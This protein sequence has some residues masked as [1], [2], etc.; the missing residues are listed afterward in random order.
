MQNIHQR[1]TV[2]NA[3]A[4]TGIDNDASAINQGLIG[5]NKSLVGICNS[6][7]VSVLGCHA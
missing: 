6:T 3:G 7:I 2:I 4:L 1:I 5:V